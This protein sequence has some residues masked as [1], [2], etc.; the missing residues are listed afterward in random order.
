MSASSSTTRTGA[1]VLGRPEG[2]LTSV[3]MHLSYLIQSAIS[4]NRGYTQ[5]RTG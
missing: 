5:F 2:R 3:A 4:N 1:D